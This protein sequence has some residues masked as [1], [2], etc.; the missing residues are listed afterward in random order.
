MDRR[1][2]LPAPSR[3]KRCGPSHRWRL[4]PY[5]GKETIMNPWNLSERKAIMLQTLQALHQ[6]GRLQPAARTRIEQLYA[7]GRDFAAERFAGLAI[8]AGT[9]SAETL[10]TVYEHLGDVL[11]ALQ[12]L[13]S[14]LTLADTLA[15]W[16]EV[17]TS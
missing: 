3:S 13:S 5:P 4:P 17:A 6:Q 15:A 11:R 7:E 10:A 1:C 8:W 12:T 16:T 14:A 2:F 9:G